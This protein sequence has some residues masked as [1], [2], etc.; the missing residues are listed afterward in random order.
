MNERIGMGAIAV[1]PFRLGEPAFQ[2]QQPAQVDAR[3][4]VIRINFEAG[5]V[6]FLRRSWLA[7]SI[8]SAIAYAHRRSGR[9]HFR[10]SAAA[11]RGGLPSG[12]VITCRRPFSSTISSARAYWPE[13]DSR[14]VGPSRMAMRLPSAVREILLSAEPSGSA[15]RSS[16]KVRLILCEEILAAR[17]RTGGAQHHE[18][19]KGVVQPACAPDRLDVAR[20]R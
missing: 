5:F 13:S 18:I 7:S 2:V 8:S 17:K 10:R 1:D 6:G 11:C 16:C 9:Q 20:A 3:F 4:Q 15:E 14:K 19:V 12:R